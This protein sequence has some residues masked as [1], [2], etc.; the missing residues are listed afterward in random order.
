MLEHEKNMLRNSKTLEICWLFSKIA[1]MDIAGFD[2]LPSI[3]ILERSAP[4]NIF[5]EIEFHGF[6]LLRHITPF[7]SVI[8]CGTIKKTTITLQI[9]YFFIKFLTFHHL[10]LTLK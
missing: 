7:I 3:Y 4:R 1:K 9:Y 8:N 5:S 10:I 2:S 6:H